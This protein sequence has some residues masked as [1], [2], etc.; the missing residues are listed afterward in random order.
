MS[1]AITPKTI[2]PTPRGYVPAVSPR[3]KVLLYIVFALFALLGANALY[4]VSITFQNWLAQTRGSGVNFENQ[5]YHWMV[6]LHVAL[7]LLFIAPFLAFG[8]IHMVTSWNRKNKRAIRVGYALFIAGIVVLV[9]GLLLFRIEGV[10]DLRHPVARSFVY[11]AHFAA[12]LAAIW[13]YWLHRLVGPRIKWKIGISYLSAVGVAVALMVGLQSIDPRKFNEVGS[14][15]GE[16]YFQPSLAHTATGKFI[17]ADTMMMDSYCLKCHKDAYEGWFHSSHHL[18]SFNNPMYLA[19]VSETREV[20]LKRD[21][22]VKA[23]RWCAG[24]HD[25]VP[26]FSGAFDDPKFDMKKHATSQAGITCTTCHS[27]THIDSTKGNAAYTIEEP[28]HY[29]FARSDNAVLQYINNQLI[30][31]KPAFHKQTFLK[32]LHKSAEFCSTCHKVHL[33]YELNHYKEFLRGQNHYDSYLLSGASGHGARSFYY[34]PKAFE[35]C[36]V[37]HMPVMASKDFGAKLFDDSGT[38]KIHDHLFPAANTGLAFVKGDAATVK[39]HE[40]FLKNGVARVDIFGI[41]EGGTVDGKLHAPLRP[42]VPTL[43]PGSKYL[44][45]TVV[46]TLKIGH[47]LTQGT[48]DSNEIWVALKVTSGGKVLGMNGG[49]GDDGTVDPWSHFINVYML[50]RNGKRI[51]RRNPQ[52]IFVP[53]Y[54]KQVPPGA[55]NTVHFELELPEKLTAPVTVEMRL[56]YRKFDQKYM[57]FVAK[58]LKPG[59]TTIDGYTPGTKYINNLP[60]TTMA[61]DTITFPVEGVAETVPPQKSAI[62][63]KDLWQRWNDYGIGLGLEGTRRPPAFGRSELRQAEA[64]FKEVEKLGRYDGPL[65]LARVYFADS[66]YD[67]GVAALGRAAAFKPPAAVAPRWTLDWLSGQIN[68]KQGH[69]PEAIEHFKSVVD[70]RTKEMIDRGFD[71]SLDIEVMNELGETLFDHARNLERDPDAKEAYDAVLQDAINTFER[72]LK[73]D[74]EDATAHYNL[75]LLQ[76]LV[77]EDAKAKEHH[78]AHLRY[79]PDDNA[80]DLAVNKARK[81]NPAANHAAEALVIYP[82][83]RPGAPG[84]PAATAAVAPQLKPIKTQTD[85]AQAGGEE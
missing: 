8:S 40:E 26:F 82:L 60:V 47:P 53:L 31:A 61:M 23:S 63:E 50:D 85:A 14:K 35:N 19:S 27:I 75:S 18:S 74:S 56:Q 67:D 45:E 29:P 71:F 6:L 72:T 5:F 83:H 37:C 7:G 15:D 41:K 70:G 57:E 13:L 55:G 32:P 25:P 46:R 49:I 69:L 33:P 11:W 22:S 62:A 78:L 1:M 39:R 59:E 20:S 2:V 80:R 12:P 81:D 66:M 34:P 52:D 3:L 9:S 21:G 10:L 51:D 65:N 68:R 42:V 44:L 28:L 54:N 84:L 17:P 30:K 16:K 36:S 38:L 58:S 64:A 48:V 76:A 79:K 24:C 43:K 4:L 77:K 73:V